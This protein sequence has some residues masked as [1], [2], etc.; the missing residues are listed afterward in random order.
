MFKKILL[1]ISI[2]IFSVI[3]LDSVQAFEVV[4]NEAPSAYFYTKEFDK[5]LL[6][7]TIPFDGEDSLSAIVVKNNGTALNLNDLRDVKLWKDAGEVGFQGMGKDE[8]IGTFTYDY[9]NYA[10]YLSDIN[11][12]V[13]SE[14]LRIFVTTEISSGPTSGRYIQFQIPSLYDE[15][16][17]GI[18]GL[19]DFGIFME[20][21]NNG[22]DT[23][24]VNS[25]SQ[26]I[27]TFTRDS[28]SPV[29]AITDPIN[30]LIIDSNSYL[31]K[32]V[33]RDQGTSTPAW[34]KIS[35]NDG[36]WINVNSITS[37]YLTWEYQWND[38]AEG[39]YVIRTQ[40]ADWLGNTELE[41]D[42]INVT[43]QFPQ[44][45]PQEPV[46]DGLIEVPE[47]IAPPM[48]IEELREAVRE[49]IKEVQQQIIE[50][51]NQ[52]IQ[53]YSAELN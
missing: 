41:G 25:S 26:S 22:P 15:N 2:F 3:V 4:N 13:P 43:V 27:R 44:E 10:W 40:S 52:L 16:G 49:K 7:V 36:P 51:L 5:L 6:D 31:I 20:S 46:D 33:A 35:I 19:N 8:E 50:L 21:K 28:L 45:A 18:F 37:N 48:T 17:D 34:V 47:P 39:D 38:I 12:A 23:S 30:N 14:G 53:L 24:V 32:G 9:S 29:S 42:S 1:I 11:V